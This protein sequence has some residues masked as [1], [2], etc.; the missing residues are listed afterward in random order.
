MNRS[1]TD[2]CKS[3]AG[4]GSIPSG[5]AQPASFT[6][7]HSRLLARSRPAGAAAMTTWRANAAACGGADDGRQAA[8]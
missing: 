3:T 1:I 4:A 8:I 6:A 5:I 7:A 2:G